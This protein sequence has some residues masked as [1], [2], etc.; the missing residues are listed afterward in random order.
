MSTGQLTNSAAYRPLVIAYRNGVPVRLEEVATVLDDVEDNK[1]AS[2]F[3]GSRGIMLAIQKQPGTNTVE[4]AAN[5]RTLLPQ[6]QR[7]VT[8]ILHP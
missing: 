3:N 4:V 7:L 8:K 1:S 5:V 2:W 6:L